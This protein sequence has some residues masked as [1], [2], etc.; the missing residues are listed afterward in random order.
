MG[1]VY[2]GFSKEEA[3]IIGLEE[4]K[5]FIKKNEG[6]PLDIVFCVIDEA[7]Y[8]FGQNMLNALNKETYQYA[9]KGKSHYREFKDR[10]YRK[11]QDD[12]GY[13]RQ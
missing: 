3:W 13:R 1:G 7:S 9:E 11:S 2:K 6:Y 10:E 4:N 12:T 5:K 8:V